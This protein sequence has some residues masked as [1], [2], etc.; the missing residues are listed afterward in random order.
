MVG[1]GVGGSVGSGSNYSESSDHN[2]TC[3]Q[4]YGI[5][6]PLFEPKLALTLAV[7]QA[8]CVAHP[9]KLIPKGAH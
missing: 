9:F 2:D 4:W 7:T 5:V 8:P 1:V 6:W 3:S